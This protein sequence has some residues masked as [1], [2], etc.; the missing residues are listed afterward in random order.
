MG[1]EERVGLWTSLFFVWLASLASLPYPYM[2]RARF[3]LFLF[4]RALKNREAVNDPVD[5]NFHNFLMFTSEDYTE[6][7][8]SPNPSAGECLA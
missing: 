4:W 7:N 2:L 8:C 5:R 1:T 3:A 6:S